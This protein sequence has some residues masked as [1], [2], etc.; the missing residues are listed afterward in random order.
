MAAGIDWPA[1]IAATAKAITDVRANKPLAPA[2]QMTGPQIAAALT[3]AQS[4]IAWAAAK[5][6]VYPGVIAGLDDVLAA[7]EGPSAPWAVDIKA[8]IDALPGGLAQ[9]Q[10]WLP[11]VLGLLGAFS[12]AATGIAGD[13]PA[14]SRGR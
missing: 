2:A 8:A 14:D 12:P 10:A 13:G 1:L 11:T 7:L 3:A 4:D 5:I 6:S 9:A